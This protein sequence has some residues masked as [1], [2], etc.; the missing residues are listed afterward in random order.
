MPINERRK[1][2]MEIEKLFD[3]GDTEKPSKNSADSS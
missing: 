3:L 1:I 2:R